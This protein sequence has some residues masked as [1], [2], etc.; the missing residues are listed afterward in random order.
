MMHRDK[1]ALAL[2]CLAALCLTLLTG[3]GSK[4]AKNALFLDYFD[5]VIEVSAWDMDEARFQEFRTLSEQCFQ[6][7]HRLFDRYHT[8]DGL[9]NLKTVNDQAGAGPVQVPQPLFDLIEQGLAS[10]QETGGALNIALG[11]V[12]DLW[13][14]AREAGLAQPESASLPDRDALEQAALLCRTDWVELNPAQATVFLKEP[15][16]ILDLGAL[17]KGYAVELTTNRLKEAGFTDF[18]I[19]AGGNVRTCGSPARGNQ[20]WNLGLQSPRKG[21]S[22]LYLTVTAGETSMVTSG[23]YQRYYTVDGTDYGHIID[24]ATLLPGDRYLS[25]TALH[26]DSGVADMLSTSLFLMEY[27]VGAAL[28]AQYGA[29]VLWI[30]PD[31]ELRCTDSLRDRI[32][33]LDQE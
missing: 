17:A 7:Y 16:M 19:N 14:A 33:V 30:L 10:V 21:D 25:V 28:A 13:S 15:G 5:T 1:K 22:S 31:G 18:L 26:P 8:Y 12:L 11:P 23:S 29:E 3:C 6:E 27:D 32:T 9:S 24:P 2:L 4:K 20:Q